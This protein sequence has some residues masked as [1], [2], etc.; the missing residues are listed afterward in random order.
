VRHYSWRTNLAHIGRLL[1][2]EPTDVSG[3]ALA[4]HA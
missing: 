1:E 2:D 4:G 3:S